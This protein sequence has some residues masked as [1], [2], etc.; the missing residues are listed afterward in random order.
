[1]IN[2]IKERILNFAL[3]VQNATTHAILIFGTFCIIYG[4]IIDGMGKSE[5]GMRL[6]IL[7]I[8]TSMAS[9]LSS[10]MKYEHIEKDRESL[11]EYVS[12][13]MSGMTELAAQFKESAKKHSDR[14]IGR[15]RNYN[16]EKLGL[17][18]EKLQFGIKNN[19]NAL[20]DTAECRSILFKEILE[21]KHI[22][23]TKTDLLISAVDSVSIPT[24]TKRKYS[25]QT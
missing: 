16:D 20:H 10:H 12:E 1:M 2:K 5:Y 8:T 9:H 21:L 13:K 23:E 3:P 24:E 15:L 11:K 4:L 19:D 7:I 17:E 25:K 6:L 18:I 14:E 22:L